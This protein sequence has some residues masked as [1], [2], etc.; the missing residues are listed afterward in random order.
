M[1]TRR[2]L[3]L[4]LLLGAA[5]SVR[6]QDAYDREATEQR[7]RELRAQIDD[8]RRLLSETEA[9]E[10]ATVQTLEQLDRQISL[11]RE[12]IRNYRRQVQQIAFEMDSLRTALNR[13]EAELDVLKRQYQSRAI[14]AYKYGRLHD[15]ALIL[16]AKS[17]NQM[18]VR[19]QYLHRFT[20]QRRDRLS[21][22]ETTGKWHHD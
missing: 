7:L 1:F 3:I 12:L 20:R 4:L 15:L 13:L 21:S 6:G 8:D 2:L 10:R 22:I 5:A 9:A 17:I 11:R 14:H 18:L 19:V 16:S